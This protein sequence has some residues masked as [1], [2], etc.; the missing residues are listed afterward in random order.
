MTSL[1]LI[2]SIDRLLSR[3]A[4]AALVVK[5]GHENVARAARDAAD[6]LRD[7]MKRGD[8]T[9]ATESDA[10]AWL[11]DRITAGL[12]SPI[13]PSIRRVINATG[14]ILHTNLGRAP[15]ARAAAARA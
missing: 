15:L 2:P 11:D 14:V 13:A 10:T 7:A 9:P 4:I 8:E 5:H 6:A 3:P 1:R 12:E